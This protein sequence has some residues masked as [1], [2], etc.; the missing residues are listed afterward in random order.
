MPRM[1]PA[2]AACKNLEVKVCLGI[3]TVIVVNLQ[4]GIGNPFAP[5]RRGPDGLAFDAHGKILNVAPVSTKYLFLENSSE[6]KINLASA[7]K[8]MAVAVAYAGSCCRAGK[9]SM[10]C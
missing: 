1:G 6:R 2:T 7:G 3:G 9:G 5:L 10:A 8:C 4:D